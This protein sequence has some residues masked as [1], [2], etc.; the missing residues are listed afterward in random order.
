MGRTWYGMRYLEAAQ[1]AYFTGDCKPQLGG[2]RIKKER[3]ESRS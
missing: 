3:P 2:L 1:L